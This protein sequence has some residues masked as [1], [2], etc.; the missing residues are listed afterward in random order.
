MALFKELL[1]PGNL[2]PPSDYMMRKVL[3]YDNPFTDFLMQPQ[4]RQMIMFFW[5]SAGCRIQMR[6]SITCA[7]EGSTAG[8]QLHAR[9]GSGMQMMSA[10]TAWTRPGS[11]ETFQHLPV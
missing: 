3:R 6:L 4:L 9:T 8:H 7:L 11:S 1:P 2:L 5:V 10:L